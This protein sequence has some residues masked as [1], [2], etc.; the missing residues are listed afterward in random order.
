MS[1][2]IISFFLSNQL[3]SIIVLLR[4]ILYYIYLTAVFSYFCRLTYMNTLWNI[5]LWLNYPT[6]DKVVKISLTSTH[7]NIEILL[8]YWFICN[9]NHGVQFCCLM[10]T[11]TFDTELNARRWLVVEYVEVLLLLLTKMISI[12]L[13]QLQQSTPGWESL[14]S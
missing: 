9:N 4:E 8:T 10:S 3:N 14:Q 11:F 1:N 12:L 6:F 5:V 7:C 2:I 13:Q